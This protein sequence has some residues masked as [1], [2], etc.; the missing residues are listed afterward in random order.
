MLKFFNPRMFLA[1]ILSIPAA[2]FAVGFL[3]NF[4]S[5]PVEIIFLT[6]VV[7]ATLGLLSYRLLGKAQHLRNAQVSELILIFALFL[8]T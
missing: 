8:A 4:Y 5:A 2:F 6:L 7:Q 1:W 3:N